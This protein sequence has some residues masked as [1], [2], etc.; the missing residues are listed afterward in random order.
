MR[1][2]EKSHDNPLSA[3]WLI[4]KTTERITSQ[5]YWPN[6]L[7]DIKS[8]VNRCEVCLA[9]KSTNKIQQ[10]PMGKYREAKR[11]WQIIYIDFIAPFVRSKGGY[12]YLLVVVDAFSKFVHIHPLRAATSKAVIDFLENRIFLTFSVLEYIHSVR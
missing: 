6:M 1:I 9:T 8:Y 7:R 12:C 4:F 10:A 5:Y 3:H 11:P 2:F